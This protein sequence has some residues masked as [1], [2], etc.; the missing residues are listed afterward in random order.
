MSPKKENSIRIARAMLS[1]SA[2]C[3]NSCTG[4][5]VDG[6]RLNAYHW[7][8]WI[9]QY[10]IATAAAVMRCC[11]DSNMFSTMHVSRDTILDEPGKKGWGKPN[12]V[13]IAKQASKSTF[14]KCILTPPEGF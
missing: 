4:S 1:G 14:K 11:F 8:V 6:M 5:L 2:P 7:K 13:E 12:N 10:A 3:S 9:A